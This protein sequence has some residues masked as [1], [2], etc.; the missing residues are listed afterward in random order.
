MTFTFHKAGT[1]DVIPVP[2]G[3]YTASLTAVEERPGGFQ[4]KG[5]RVWKFVADVN[6]EALPVDGVTGIANSDHPKNRSYQWLTAILGAP[7]Q[8]GVPI[9]P[10]G[11]RCL[12]TVGQ[13]DGYPRVTDVLPYDEPQQVVAGVPR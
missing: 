7:P 12:V 10:I 13:K 4:G 3:T 8:L 9:D 5:F 11:K 6:G 1:G 2:S